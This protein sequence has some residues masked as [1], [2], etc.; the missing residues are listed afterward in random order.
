[1]EKYLVIDI[2]LQRKTIIKFMNITTQKIIIYICLTSLFVFLSC[3]PTQTKVYK[4]CKEQVETI[5]RMRLYAT[6][7]VP[8][9]SLGQYMND[10]VISEDMYHHCEVVANVNPNQAH[11]LA[12]LYFDKAGKVR[13]SIEWWSDGGDLRNVSY[14]NNQGNVIYAIY[15]YYDNN[16]GKLYI[17]D[18]KHYIEYPFSQPDNKHKNIFPAL[19]IS[20]L[21]SEY[22]VHLQMPINCNTVSFKS[23]QEG[24]K[25]FLC[26]ENIY[27][28]PKGT[29]IKNEN[30]SVTWFGKL[31]RIDSIVN[32]W[33]R[34]TELL[35]NPIGYVQVDSIELFQRD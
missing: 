32:D 16:C 3:T 25:A 31:I 34:V 14:Y 28:T 30:A 17:N 21:V 8:V 35:G 26:T 27:A 6:Y 1:M 11:V 9:D 33:C 19:N 13:K 23:I 10:E 7:L 2:N 18:S 5:N 12:I 4:Q 29:N 15:N 24:D 22:K 20:E